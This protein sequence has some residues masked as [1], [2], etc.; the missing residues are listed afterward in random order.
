MPKKDRDSY[1]AVD[2]ILEA[3]NDKCGELRKL[4]ENYNRAIEK[5][6]ENVITE[7]DKNNKIHHTI[8]WGGQRVDLDSTAGI[9]LLENAKD[10]IQ[11]AVS[12][13]SGIGTTLMQA[14]RLVERKMT[15]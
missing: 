7:V 13:C 12:N 3:I 5:I 2:S 8:A 6:F 10:A 11:T 1:L 9:A 14:K 15:A 4:V